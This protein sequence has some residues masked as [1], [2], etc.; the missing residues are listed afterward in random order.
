MTNR[1]VRI[2]EKKNKKNNRKRTIIQSQ[3][4]VESHN[5]KRRKI[6][7]NITRSIIQQPLVE[8]SGKPRKENYK[9]NLKKNK[10]CKK[11]KREKWYFS[12]L[13]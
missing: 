12:P 1:E 13:K 9:R 3:L 11:N 5:W 8:E 2:E 10:T 7:N 4:T 6:Q